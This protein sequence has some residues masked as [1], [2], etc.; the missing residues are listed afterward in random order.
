MGGSGG[1]PRH[2]REHARTWGT[3]ARPR[4]TRA[5]GSML[6]TRRRRAGGATRHTMRGATA[7]ADAL[8]SER[9]RLAWRPPRTGLGSDAVGFPRTPGRLLPPAAV[10]PGLRAR[11]S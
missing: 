9:A 1:V 2:V 10:G 6:P 8:P 3:R 5:R 4:T 7:E 11:R